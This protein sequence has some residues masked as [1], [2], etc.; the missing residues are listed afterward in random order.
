VGSPAMKRAVLYSLAGL[1]VAIL[2]VMWYYAT[3]VEGMDARMLR[4]KMCTL[5]PNDA[6]CMARPH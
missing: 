1:V 3:W 2:C 4:M 6:E 5:E